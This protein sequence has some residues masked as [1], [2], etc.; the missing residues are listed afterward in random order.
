MYS[1]FITSRHVASWLGVHQKFNRVAYRKV[2]SLISAK[3]WPSLSAIQHF[4]GMNGPDG[5]KVKTVR[6]DEEP[7]HFYNPGTKS[8]E[9]LDYI[10]THFDSLV[11]A[12]QNQNKT[13]AAFDASWLAHSITD[14]LTPAHHIPYQSALTDLYSN[15]GQDIRRPKDK[16]VIQANNSWQLL[17]NNWRMWGHNGL[18]S[19]HVHFELGVAMLVLTAR[20]QDVMPQQSLRQAQHLGLREYFTRN[21]QTVHDWGLYRQFHR[22]GWTASLARTVRWELTPMIIDTVA[23]AWALAAEEAR[24]EAR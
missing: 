9:L 16:V 17:Q 3:A 19:S 12:L 8:Q 11:R 7:M 15:G 2:R 20:F 24:G 10:D 1:G 21:A 4:E 14:G 23:I 18:L 22:Y 6:R 5:M 13:R